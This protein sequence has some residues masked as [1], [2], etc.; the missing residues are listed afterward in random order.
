M[1]APP[2]VPISEHRY[3]V[4]NVPIETLLDRR[5]LD[6]MPVLIVADVKMLSALAA[7]RLTAYVK[8]GGMLLIIPGP[9]TQPDTYTA[10]TSL[11]PAAIEGVVACEPPLRPAAANFTHPWLEPFADLTIDSINDRLAFR[12]LALKPPAA[13]AT[14]VLAFADGTPALLELRVGKGCAAFFAFSMAAD[15]GQFGTQAAPAIVLLHRMLELAQP[16]LDNLAALIAG[17]ASPRSIAGA[18]GSPLVVRSADGRELVVPVA[19]NRTCRLPADL[20]QNYEAAEKTAQT[21]A[22]MYYSVNVSLAESRPGRITADQ[23]KSKLDRN[24]TSVLRPG[25]RPVN[26]LVAGR[27]RISWAVP[28]GLFLALL[29][30]VESAF[31]NRFYRMPG[32]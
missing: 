3:R 13:G 28:L 18:S 4:V 31:A 29:L 20:P 26:G 17:P 5:D 16:P 15:W 27:S 7:E 2:A 8:N 25:D 6:S 24:L 21:P 14:V 9:N 11:L 30:A 1:I 22:V 32:R 19:S 12:R 23:A 10:A